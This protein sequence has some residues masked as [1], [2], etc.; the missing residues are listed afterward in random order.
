MAK[1]SHCLS[2]HWKQLGIGL[3]TRCSG[4]LQRLQIIDMLYI[5]PL[6][7]VALYMVKGQEQTSGYLHLLLFV[8]YGRGKLNNSS[9]FQS[10]GG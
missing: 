2:S 9:L 5:P 8:H 10:P 7:L 1:G 6:Q 4:S 3:F